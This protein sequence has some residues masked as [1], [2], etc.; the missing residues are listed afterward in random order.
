[1]ERVIKINCKHVY[2]SGLEYENKASEIEKIQKKLI[3]AG[4]DIKSIWPSED[5]HN[6]LVSYNEHILELN[7]IIEFLD[8]EAY[9]LKGSALEHSNVDND[10]SDKMKRSDDYDND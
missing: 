4:E 8:E 7:N 10:F 6:F 3:K 1:M 9:I 2:E 5:G